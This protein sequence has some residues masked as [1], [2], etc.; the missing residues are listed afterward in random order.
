MSEEIDNAE[1]WVNGS[2]CVSDK[3]K[4]KSCS[5]CAGRILAKAYRTAIR[6]RDAAR[7]EAAGLR[8]ALAARDRVVE[9]ARASLEAGQCTSAHVTL[10]QALAA[11]D[12][13]DA[14]R[15]KQEVE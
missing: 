13:Q 8:A 6:E 3:I 15:S 14:L 7:A 5:V 11:I 2:E 10:R 9:I 12:G 1:R 4:C